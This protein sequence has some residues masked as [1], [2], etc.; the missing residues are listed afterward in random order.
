MLTMPHGGTTLF[1]ATNH[2]NFH[3]PNAIAFHVCGEEVNLFEGQRLA[4]ML[5]P[6]GMENMVSHESILDYNGD[7]Y[8]KPI[9]GNRLSF[10]D[11]GEIMSKIQGDIL[12]KNWR[13]IL[14]NWL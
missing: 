6:E 13:H 14:D 8:S 11:A 5:F 4:T 10:E 9:M 2:M 12:E 1:C 3:E 7:N